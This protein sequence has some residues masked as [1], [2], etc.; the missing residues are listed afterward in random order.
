[1][2]KEKTVRNN[3]AGFNDVR[4]HISGITLLGVPS[5]IYSNGTQYLIVGAI[6]V[7]VIV[8]V[9]Y[10]F[11]PVFYELQCTSIYEVTSSPRQFVVRLTISS[12]P[13]AAGGDPVFSFSVFGTPIQ[14]QYSR[15][16]VADFRRVLNTVHTGGDLHTGVGVQSR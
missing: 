1:L 14:L 10:V 9:I 5:E 6:N 8:T 13:A 12:V 7:I 15:V 11:L 3:R 16:I 2:R 4:S